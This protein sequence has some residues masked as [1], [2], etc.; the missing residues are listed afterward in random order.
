MRS[1]REQ[2]TTMETSQ[3]KTKTKLQYSMSLNPTEMYHAVMYCTNGVKIQ[4]VPRFQGTKGNKG[5]RV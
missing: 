2:D 5:A 3:N 4:K 1:N